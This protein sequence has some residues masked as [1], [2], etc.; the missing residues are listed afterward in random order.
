MNS[1]NRTIGRPS[2]IREIWNCIGQE[3][4]EKGLSC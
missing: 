2:G 1:V 4:M 3:P